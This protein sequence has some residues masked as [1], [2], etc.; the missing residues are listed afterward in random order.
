MP[1]TEWADPIAGDA[2]QQGAHMLEVTRYSHLLHRRRGVGAAG[3]RIRGVESV[4]FTVQVALGH[5]DLRRATGRREQ[6]R[7]GDA[8]HDARD[9]DRVVAEVR[10]GRLQLAPSHEPRHAVAGALLSFVAAGGDGVRVRVHAAAAAGGVVEHRRRV[11]GL[12]R[13]QPRGA[14][15]QAQVKGRPHPGGAG[16]EREVDGDVPRAAGRAVVAVWVEEDC[17]LV[18][19]E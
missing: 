14:V 8:R 11:L 18:P 19:A 2:R 15:D 10:R 1:L 9:G 6:R 16:D 17:P 7:P 5:P 4:G 12:E 3:G 13:R